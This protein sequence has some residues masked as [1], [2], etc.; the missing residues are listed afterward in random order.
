MADVIAFPKTKP[1]IAEDFS[2]NDARSTMGRFIKE[3]AGY[4]WPT[5]QIYFTV[6]KM[7]AWLWAEGFKLVPLTDEDKNDAG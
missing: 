1:N 3:N 7:L 6:D 4:P 5:E 2:D